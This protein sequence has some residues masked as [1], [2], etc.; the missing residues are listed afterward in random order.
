MATRVGT[1]ALL[2]CYE[3]HTN[4]RTRL[5]IQHVCGRCT[6]RATRQYRQKATSSRAPEL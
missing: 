3:L 6:A 2:R 5:C 1:N 4:G